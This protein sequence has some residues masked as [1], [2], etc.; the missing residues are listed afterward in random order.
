MSG[1]D[2]TWSDKNNCLHSI[3]K[4]FYEKIKIFKKNIV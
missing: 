4:Y 2:S 1:I 3:L